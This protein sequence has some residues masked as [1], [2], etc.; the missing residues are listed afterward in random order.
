MAQTAEY[1][2][3]SSSSDQG[4]TGKINAEAMHGWNPILMTSVSGSNGITVYVIM[5]HK[6]GT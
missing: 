4:L 3:V 5:E 1:K 2:V 6:V